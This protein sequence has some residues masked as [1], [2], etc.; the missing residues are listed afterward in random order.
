MKRTLLCFFAFQ[1][2]AF[3]AMG[4]APTGDLTD[5]LRIWM[6]GEDSLDDTVLP[7]AMKLVLPERTMSIRLSVSNSTAQIVQIDQYGIEGNTIK[8]RWMKPDGEMTGNCWPS[9]MCCVTLKY[10]VPPTYGLT[11]A[12]GQCLSITD[13]CPPE[14]AA[15]NQDDTIN[16]LCKYFYE[17]FTRSSP[18]CEF[19]YKGLWATYCRDATSVIPPTCTFTNQCMLATGALFDLSQGGE[20]HIGFFV[21]NGSNTAVTVGQPLFNDSRLVVHSPKIGYSNEVFAVDSSATNATVAARGTTEWRVPWTNLWNRLPAADRA[22][23]TEAHE[24][25]LY[26]RTPAF[27][28]DALPLWL[29]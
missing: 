24:V 10:P 29:E 15:V 11:I 18:T 20:P 17:G 9:T 13:I 21:M 4:M 8:W 16:K 3:R 19:Y 25:D 27:T 22:L 2:I 1:T 12:P 26:W 6:W 5:D 7:A 14:A 28:S 23:L